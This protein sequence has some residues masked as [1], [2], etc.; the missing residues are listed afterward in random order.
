MFILQ[1]F[2]LVESDYPGLGDV[3]EE[4][5]GFDHPKKNFD[6]TVIKTMTDEYYA[7][8]GG[9]LPLALNTN[10]KVKKAK[11]KQAAKLL[12]ETAKT[13]TID[14]QKSSKTKAECNLEQRQKLEEAK[15]IEKE[16]KVD[17]KEKIKQLN[18]K[19]D[20]ASEFYDIPKVGW[21]K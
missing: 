15:L 7:V 12:T 2:I 9:K 5:D 19:L 6:P 20:N 16:A 14:V 18:E 10:K 13:E 1:T 3:V 17:Y 11:K 4:E 8:R 21:T